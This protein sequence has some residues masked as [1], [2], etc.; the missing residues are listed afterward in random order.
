MKIK[1]NYSDTLEK[2]FMKTFLK[3]KRKPRRLSKKNKKIITMEKF[4]KQFFK[5]L[6]EDFLNDVYKLHSKAFTKTKKGDSR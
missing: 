4:S 5:V 3:M 2:M 1:G 6:H